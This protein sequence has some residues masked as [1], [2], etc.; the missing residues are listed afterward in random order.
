MMQSAASARDD[1]GAPGVQEQ[2]H[3][4]HRQHGALDQVWRTFV[5]ATRMGR[6]LSLITS[7]RTPAAAGLRMSTT[8]FRPS[9]TSMVFSSCALHRQQQRALAVVERQAFHLLRAIVHR[10]T[11]SRRMGAPALACRRRPRATMMRPKSSGALH[12]G[13]DLHHA[14]LGQRADGPRAGPGFRCARQRPPARA[15][16]RRSPAPAGSGRC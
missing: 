13:V 15:S 5:T 1:R 16:R 12:A 6:E 7:S 14:F 4:E 9:T 10:A 11:W 2:E 3:D 8:A